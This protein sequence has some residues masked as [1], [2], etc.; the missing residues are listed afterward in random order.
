M[1]RREATP[2]TF[3][4]Q[5]QEPFLPG[6]CWEDQVANRKY[7]RYAKEL[8]SGA[9]IEERSGFPWYVD[10][11]LEATV[12]VAGGVLS[13]AIGSGNTA[14]VIGLLDSSPLGQEAP[15]KPAAESRI[16]IAATLIIVPSN[17]VQQWKDEII[18]F[19]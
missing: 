12:R 18:K 6:V 11:S 3:R 2:G 19:R 5:L 8:T 15:P 13:D 7:Y 17:L 10:A 9:E 1:L 16:P 4:T 14:T